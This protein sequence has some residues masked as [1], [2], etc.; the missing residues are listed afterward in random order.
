MRI[1]ELS[2]NEIKF[3]RKNYKESL[4][5]SIERIGFSF[6]IKVKHSDGEYVCVD[7]HKRLSALEDLIHKGSKR[8]EMVKVII[9]DSDDNRSNDCSRGRN[10]H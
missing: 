2:I 1:K 5:N 8:S 7:G 9:V 4:M 10:V 3:E 6:P